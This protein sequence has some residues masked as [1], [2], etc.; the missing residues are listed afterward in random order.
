MDGL[1][2]KTIS[3][4]CPFKNLQIS[5][6]P[7]FYHGRTSGV[8]SKRLGDE[9]LKYFSSRKC[10]ISLYNTVLYQEAKS[11]VLQ[12]SRLPHILVMS[13]IRTYDSQVYKSL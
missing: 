7:T 4:Y 6:E 1:R 2:Q 3:R 12:P 9:T 10:T 5:K 11:S 8:N 13:Y